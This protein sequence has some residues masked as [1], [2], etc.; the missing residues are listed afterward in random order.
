MR[1][2]STK[3][4][5]SHTIDTVSLF[6]LTFSDPEFLSWKL[7]AQTFPISVDMKKS[8]A[9]DSAIQFTA[10]ESE[11]GWVLSSEVEIEMSRGLGSIIVITNVILCDGS[12]IFPHLVLS[13]CNDDR[14]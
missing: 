12:T 6:L 9:N 14:A 1:I 8:S 11:G 13:C 10:I 5:M 7:Q 4:K 2:K 3:T